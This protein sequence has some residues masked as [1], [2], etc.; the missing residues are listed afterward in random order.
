MRNRPTS[1]SRAGRLLLHIAGLLLCV[2]P[3]TLCTLLYFPVW[4]QSSAK[5]L[6]GGTLLILMLS[7]YP[8][9]KLIRRYL[10]SP[11]A[12]LMWLFIFIGFLLLSAIAYEMTVISFFGF[13]GNLLGAVCFKAADK[14]RSDI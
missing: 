2:I 12:Y 3:P 11:S 10:R 1:K 7:A 5:T 6:A 4:R 9:V 14:G 8:I 13:L